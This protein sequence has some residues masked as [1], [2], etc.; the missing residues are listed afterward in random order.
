MDLT[1]V[2]VPE[3][4][5]YEV[6]ADGEVVGFS[7]Y[8]LID[9]GVYALPHVEVDPAFEG[10]G[11]ASALMRESLDDIRERGLK[12]VPICPFARAYIG[13]NRGYADLVHEG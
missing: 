7:A 5:R 4:S 1:V 10:R 9:E 6:S 11:V 12:V 2:D 3:R 8:H 13:K